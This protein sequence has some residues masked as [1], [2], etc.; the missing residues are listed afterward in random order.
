[1]RLDDWAGSPS[2][3]NGWFTTAWEKGLFGEVWH[4]MF[5][6]PWLTLAPVSPAQSSMLWVGRLGA[7]T[8]NV[9]RQALFGWCFFPFAVRNTGIQSHSH[10]QSYFSLLEWGWRIE[11]DHQVFSMAGSRLAWEKGLFGKVWHIIF[12]LLWLTLAPVSPAQSSMLWVGRL[13][14]KTF[15]VRRQALFGWCFFPLQCVILA[16]N[17]TATNKV[18][19]HYWNEAG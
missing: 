17:H 12:L 8:F 14:A 18:I 13:G 16:Y 5:L 15:N 10:Q 19:V 4:L 7:K 1:M 6:L 2:L 9:R 11:Q 3:F